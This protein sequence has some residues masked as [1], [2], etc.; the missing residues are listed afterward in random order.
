MARPQ[1]APYVLDKKKRRKKV[2][3]YVFVTLGVFMLYAIFLGIV[4][5][6]LRSPLF[7][8]DAVTVSGAPGVPT[9]TIV[10]LV[11]ADP[12]G[13]MT[14]GWIGAMF[15]WGSMFAWPNGA[16]PSS[17]RVMDPSLSSVTVSKNYFT[18]TVA[19]DAVERQPFGIWCFGAGGGLPLPGGT[20]S[21]TAA[22][23]TV[24]SGVFAPAGTQCYWFD[25]TG[26]MFERS[27]STTGN[28]IYMVSD[29]SQKDRGLGNTVLPAEFN[30]NFLSIMDVLRGLG[31]GIKAI[32]L[33]DLALEE[34]DVQTAPGPLIEFSLRFPA[35]NYLPVLQNLAAQ[36]GFANIHYIDC[37]TKDRVFYK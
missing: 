7:R 11:Q 13:K 5:I 29:Y 14:N 10:A 31:L 27:L 4:W 22:S 8:V 17:T 15:G 28:L 36:P 26:V 16:V 34:I 1:I 6:F 24:P 23:G 30:A 12:S 20:G 21:S 32:D 37:R 18:H 25:D 3:L 33:K 19:I 9:S 2:R 35:N